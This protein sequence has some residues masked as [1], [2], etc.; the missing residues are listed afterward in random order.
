M[1]VQVKNQDIFVE[2]FHHYI[3]V[4][5]YLISIHPNFLRNSSHHH[6]IGS[7]YDL[8]FQ[9][10]IKIKYMKVNFFIEIKKYEISITY[11]I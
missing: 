11:L 5:Q 3:L 1:S 6:F 7:K 8:G 9:N 10:I 4:N 2:I